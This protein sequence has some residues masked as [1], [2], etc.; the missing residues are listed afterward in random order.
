MM[1]HIGVD[2]LEGAVNHLF[3][4]IQRQ[5]ET[6]DARLQAFQQVDGHQFLQSLLAAR[7]SQMHATFIR[8]NLVF[9][10][11]RGQDVV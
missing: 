9:R 8:L 5:A 7:H 3:H 6:V 10:A 4:A 2:S 11:L 1:R